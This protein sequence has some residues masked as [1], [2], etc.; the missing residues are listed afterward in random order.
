MIHIVVSLTRL[1][2][3][4]RVTDWRIVTGILF[5]PPEGDWGQEMLSF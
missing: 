3:L 5:P 4:A 1:H 2:H